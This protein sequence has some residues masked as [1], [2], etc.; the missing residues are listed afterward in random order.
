[1]FPFTSFSILPVS[2]VSISF[3]EP[4]S[5]YTVHQKYLNSA[6]L[7]TASSSNLMFPTT[8]SPPLVHSVL[9]LLSHLSS[10]DLIHFPKLVFASSVFAV[11]GITSSA[12]IISHGVSI[13][14]SSVRQSMMIYNKQ[15]RTQRGTLVHPDSN[16]ERLSTSNLGQATNS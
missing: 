14:S 7:R 16:L 8:L 11:L 10:N 5:S 1:M 13:L 9:F 6:V 3:F 2:P 12:N 15:D 4:P